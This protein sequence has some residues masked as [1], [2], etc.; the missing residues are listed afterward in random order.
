MRKIQLPVV[1]GWSK[2][3]SM[4]EFPSSLL[5]TLLQLFIRHIILKGY[6]VFPLTSGV[7]CT[8][9]AIIFFGK[10]E[11]LNCSHNFYLYIFIK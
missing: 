8:I 6:C 2:H 10:I 4:Y 11:K 1:E 3:I 9:S 7:S 5:N